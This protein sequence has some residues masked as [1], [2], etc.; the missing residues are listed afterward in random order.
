MIAP[1]VSFLLGEVIC[2]ELFAVNLISGSLFSFSTNL[3]KI[4]RLDL[5][6]PNEGDIFWIWTGIF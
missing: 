2:G 4:I 5:L 6:F 3:R 1:S